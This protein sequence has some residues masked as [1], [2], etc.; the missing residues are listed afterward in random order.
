MRTQK[1]SSRFTNPGTG[2]FG[3]PLIGAL[4]RIPWE[5]VRRRMLER[6]HE[7]GF[8]DLETAHL[9]VFQFP[10][11]QGAKPSELASRLGSSKQSVN[12]LLGQLERLGY[13][14]RRD[15]PDDGRSRRIH[16]TPR[17]RAAI[18]AIREAVTEVERGWERRLGSK[19]LEALRLLLRELCG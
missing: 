7:R 10:G 16:V 12:H 8:V 14:E 17:G 2:P 9:S 18:A 6:L 1:K 19:R 5:T 13:L 11:P 15:D 3:P 4:L